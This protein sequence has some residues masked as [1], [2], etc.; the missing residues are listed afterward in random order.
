MRLSLI[1]ISAGVFLDGLPSDDM[2]LSNTGMYAKPIPVPSGS[3]A[4][5]RLLARLGRHPGWTS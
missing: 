2:A 4:Q 5:S 3:D 1:Q